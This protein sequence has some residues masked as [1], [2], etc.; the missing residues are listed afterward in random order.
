MRLRL[1]TMFRAATLLRPT[2]PNSAIEML[3]IEIA[4]SVAVTPTGQ[5][6]I[7]G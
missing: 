1:V 6:Y 2:R 4:H 3:L 5:D 7:A